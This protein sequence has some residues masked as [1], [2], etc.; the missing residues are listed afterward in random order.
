M[1]VV[2]PAAA[3]GGYHAH[4]Y[5]DPDTR[6]RGVALREEAGKRFDVVL[7]RVRD[8]PV[9]PHR[10]PMF[11]I[12]FAPAEFA[13]LVPWLMVNHQG[14]SIFIHPITGKDAEDHRDNA[15]WIN[16]RLGVRTD[17]LT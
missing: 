8:R 5:F 3:I 9:G 16:E 11:Q 1:N 15:L 4:V 10:K 14:L 13:R 6:A 12:A 2:D 17:G 7:G